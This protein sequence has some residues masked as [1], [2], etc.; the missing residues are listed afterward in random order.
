MK[1]IW[2]GLVCAVLSVAMVFA[3]A[4]CGGGFEAKM[5]EIKGLEI[6]SYGIAVQK[7]QD[8]D[9]LAEINNV[10]ADWTSGS[11]GETKIDKLVDYYSDVY[12]EV[13]DA[14]APFTL[15]LEGDTSSSSTLTVATEAGFA[16]FE[17]SDGNKIV[18]VDI[19]IMGQVAKNMGKKLAVYNIDFNSLNEAIFTS[20]R[21]DCIAAGFTITQERADAM[22]FSNP[23]FTSTQYIVCAEDADI[24]SLADLAGEKIGA[25]IGTTGAQL[26]DNEIKNGVLKNTGAELNEYQNAPT[27]F[28]DLK[29]GTI[30]AIVVDS[31]PATC[32]VAKTK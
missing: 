32:L 29:K 17:F 25:Q 21:A 22:D 15:Y 8:A 24:T 28:E 30:K 7:G 31:V 26:V 1:K 16:P 12:D 20:N 14:E 9:L 11:V 13:E 4:A 5:V 27:A 3:L 19:A 23:Y 10:I 2:K 18:G 6:E